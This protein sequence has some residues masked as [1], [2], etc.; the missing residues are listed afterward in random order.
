[1]INVY[2][3]DKTIYDGDSSIDFYLYC[4]KRHPRILFLLPK[5]FFSFVKYKLKLENKITFKQDFFSFFQLIPNLEEEITNFWSINI[6][7]IK[8][9]YLE[10]KKSDDI[11]ISASPE[12]LLKPMI[13]LLQVK[14]VIASNVSN[15]GLF[16]SNNCYGKEKVKRYKEKYNY[17][18]ENFFSDSYSD[19]PLAKISRKAFIVKRNKVVCWEVQDDKT[20][21]K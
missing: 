11:I 7:K 15:T 12:I 13:K 18:I 8:A 5:Q 1:M 17:I 6:K 16:L 14:D 3:F 4:L 9:W 19:L 2:D 20:N 21:K 10:Q